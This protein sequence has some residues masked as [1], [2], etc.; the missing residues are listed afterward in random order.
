MRLAVVTATLPILLSTSAI[1]TAGDVYKCK[2]SKGE[3]IYQSQPCPAGTKP[4]GT[5]HFEPVVDDPHQARAAAAEA[6]RIHADQAA[7]AANV[8]TPVEAPNS[9]AGA[10][11]DA[12]SIASRD[13]RSSAYREWKESQKSASG[14][15]A[16]KYNEDRKRW[17]SRLAGP[18]PAGY[19]A[20]PPA[21]MSHA[22]HAPSAPV[23][24]S[25]TT[26]AGGATT[27]F[28]SDGS[29]SNGHVNPS[30]NGTLFGSDG[31]IQNV[32]AVP[33]QPN[34]TCIRDANGFCN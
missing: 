12:A 15:A 2:G 6:D 29:I 19:D 14:E 16:R 22:T 10:Q 23:A 30:G 7:A 9:Y 5:A 11:S 20:S 4:L 31:S 28:G 32:Q 24:Q 26:G 25:C 27:C 1:T 33:K 13:S 8:Y 17:G 21:P 3:T 18:P 34:S